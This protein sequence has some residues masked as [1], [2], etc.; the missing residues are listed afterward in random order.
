M[1]AAGCGDKLASTPAAP[2]Q[3]VI[4]GRAQALEMTR[5]APAEIALLLEIGHLR[6]PERYARPGQAGAAAPARP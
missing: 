4:R 1:A 5:A 3:A 6:T 2:E